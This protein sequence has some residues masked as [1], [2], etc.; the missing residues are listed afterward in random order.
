MSESLKKPY[1]ELAEAGHI[2]VDETGW[3]ERGKLE[4]VWVF[5]LAL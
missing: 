3:K 1:E 4:W 5:R 2:H